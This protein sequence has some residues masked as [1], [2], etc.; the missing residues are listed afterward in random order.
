MPVP[1]IPQK[2]FWEHKPLQALTPDEWEALCDGCAR[3]CVHRFID[4]TS[5]EL[6][7][8]DVACRLLDLASCRCSRYEQRF[9]HV[10]DCLRLTPDNV[11]TCA[12]LPETCAYRRLAEGRPLPGWHPL[13]T[14][15][16]DSTRRAGM[17]MRNRL[18]S[19]DAVD[20][21]EE[22]ILVNNEGGTPCVP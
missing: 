5:G 16:P 6:Y 21:I 22:R 7:Y 12:G 18:V 3:C 13:V 15:N 1:D 11:G 2:P 4:E 8:T 17:S 9:A 14:G 10:S 19:E 20:D